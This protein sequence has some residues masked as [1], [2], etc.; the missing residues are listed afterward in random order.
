MTS[1]R[2]KKKKISLFS[3]LSEPTT[4][5]A[6][7]SSS[8]K[9]KRVP[10]KDKGKAFVLKVLL[11]FQRKTFLQT[12]TFRQT[13][14]KRMLL[15][16]FL[17]LG[18]GI[19]ILAR[20]NFVRQRHFPPTLAAPARLPHYSFISQYHSFCCFPRRGGAA[21]CLE[22][23]QTKPKWR[24]G[25]KEEWRFL[26]EECRHPPPPPSPPPQ[27]ITP[28]MMWWKNTST[29]MEPWQIDR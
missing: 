27:T 2:V 29:P 28:P 22:G 1:T 25:E 10:S 24:M 18:N 17:L 9:F 11:L 6:L 21:L 3:F 7:Q 14:P 26:A 12:Q 23:Q 16:F 13:S 20:A 8:R 4:L 15:L 19:V 5:A